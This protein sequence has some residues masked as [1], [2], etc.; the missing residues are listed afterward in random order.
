MSIKLDWSIA[1]LGTGYHARI[2]RSLVPLRNA[3]KGTVLVDMAAGADTYTDSTAPINK[4]IYYRIAFVNT[5]GV[6][7]MGPIQAKGNFPNGT[8]PGPREILR[9]D[10]NTGYFGKVLVADMISGTDL[11]AALGLTTGFTAGLTDVQ[12]SYYH[13]WV[14][15]GEI[16]FVPPGMLVKNI[17]WVQAYNL[18]LMYGTNDNGPAATMGITGL[19]AKN[20]LTRLTLENG[21]FHVR[22]PKCFFAPLDQFLPLVDANADINIYNRTEWEKISLSLYSGVGAYAG[23]GN[24]PK[25]YHYT[26]GNTEYS[27]MGSLSQHLI[28]ASGSCLYRGK[29][30]GNLDTNNSLATKSA[31]YGWVPILVLEF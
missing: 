17:S 6:E 31:T 11:K 22:T 13:K 5:S 29:P 24:I 21:T 19:V 14:I 15:E 10:W 2:Y 18:G 9:G 3:E 16:I 1:K 4:V 30:G 7:S 20:Q 28:A 27:Q 12:L 25:M 23:Q 8:G 26:T